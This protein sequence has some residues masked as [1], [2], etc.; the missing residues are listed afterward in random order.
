MQD[1]EGKEVKNGQPPRKHIWVKKCR[2]VCGHSMNR[3]VCHVSELTGEASFIYQCYGQ[4]LN[5]EQVNN[6]CRQQILES[7]DDKLKAS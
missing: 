6:E 4:I 2:C 3:R 7:E 1:S 5:L